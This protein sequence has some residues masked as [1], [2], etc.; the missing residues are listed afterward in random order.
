MK[1]NPSRRSVLKNLMLT[2]FAGSVLFT[3]CKGEN[4]RSA[5]VLNIG[6]LSLDT[7][8]NWYKYCRPILEWINPHVNIDCEA[9]V[10]T[11]IR[12]AKA[13]Q[14]N[15]V[16]FVMDYGGSPLYNG[17]SE[18]KAE[19]IGDFDLIRQLE[20]RLHE[21]D[22]FFVIAQFGAH[23]QSALGKNHPDWLMRDM[24]GKEIYGPGSVALM[25]FNSPYTEYAATEL[26]HIVKNYKTDGIYIEGLFYSMKKCYC[27][28]CK[29]KFLLEY[30]T[31]I[32][33]TPHV[34]DMS[35]APF[36][37]KS[38]NSFVERIYTSVKA[39]SPSTV[40]M[41]CPVNNETG[42]KGVITRIDWKELGKV[43]D[44]VA[45][46]RMWGYGI[47]YPLWKIGLNV[48]CMLAES[49]KECFTTTWYGLHVDREYTPRTK[50]H[51]QLNYYEPLIHGATPQTHTQNALE[52]APDSIPV[53]NELY[54]YT[55]KIRPY[56]FHAKRMSS[57]SILYDRDNFWA[58]DHFS[59]YYKALLYNHIPFKVISRDDLNPESLSETFV[60]ILPN[61]IRLEDSEIEQ[62]KSFT[63][64]GGTLIATYKTGFQDES[65]KT[66][67]IAGFLGV[68][69]F[70]GENI[71][72]SRPAPSYEHFRP[73][74]YRSDLCHYFRNVKGSFAD[75]ATKMSL[76]S[77]TGGL[78]EV[79]PGIDAT[80]VSNTLKI[81]KTRQGTQHPVYGFYPGDVNT[82]LI[83][84][85][86]YEK[87]RIV[88]FA[89]GIDRSF[90]NHGYPYLSAILMAALSPDKLPVSAEAPS[91]VEI[92]FYKRPKD[93]SI[94]I[95]LL[96]ATTNDRLS[97]DP[98][99][100]IIPVRNIRIRVKDYQKV[101]SL[102]GQTLETSIKDGYL[103]ITVPDL[104]VIDTLVVV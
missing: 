12:N 37:M 92:T 28:N 101:V 98:V 7:P 17:S 19:I 26:S 36:Y 87:G 84:E 79:E 9:Y 90:L 21:E 46:E 67:S 51:L 8:E 70:M 56:F 38:I 44:V 72:E 64:S 91:S 96:N 50:G 41:A 57:V 71:A 63:A 68:K 30:G 53:L 86:N 10:E 83:L 102:S 27:E 77:F 62:I 66:S 29:K 55:E 93:D 85:R 99:I 78:L 60:L 45:L 40:I 14:V 100:D 54:S 4:T 103:H 97:P 6:D 15:T 82:P 11:V 76:L 34:S 25:C 104:E 49:K 47:N 89:G 48:N 3:S 35:L 59:G 24:F 58:D 5:A 88:Y 73:E 16:Y 2:P 52:E 39:I 61:T 69:N 95:H 74:Y 20:K 22:M 43:C 42:N 18:P 1:N 81:D 33:E 65:A 23:T 80:I 31:N 75:E 32:P 94:L 13:A